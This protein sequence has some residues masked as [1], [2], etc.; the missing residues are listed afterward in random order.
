MPPHIDHAAASKA[1]DGKYRLT[2]QPYQDPDVI[3]GEVEAWAKK[4][5]LKV[6]VYGKECSWY[7]P[8]HTC[9]V[10]VEACDGEC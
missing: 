10:V 8:G 1:A 9:L 3:C 4:K 5:G 7:Y 6:T 2:Y